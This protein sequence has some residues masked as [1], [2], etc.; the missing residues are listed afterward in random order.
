MQTQRPGIVTGSGGRPRLNAI[1][2]QQVPVSTD[3]QAMQFALQASEYKRLLVFLAILLAGLALTLLRYV[4]GRER[5]MAA[6]T[7]AGVCTYAVAVAYAVSLLLALRAAIRSGR[8]LPSWVW[9]LSTCIEAMVPVPMMVAVQADAPTTSTSDLPS[10]SLMLYGVIIALSVLRLRP[11]LCLVNGAIG[12]AMW[13]VLVAWGIVSG[14]S[15][16]NQVV[17]LRIGYGVMLLLTGVAAAVVAGEVR[18]HVVAALRE[19]ETRRRLDRVRGDLEIARSIQQGLLP[20][21]PPQVNGYQVAGWNLPADQTGGDYYDWQQMPDGRWAMAIADV[22]GH[23]IGP[24]LIMAACRAYARA[25]LPACCDLPSALC[26]INDLLSPDITGG[27]FI[28]FAI[29]M[30]DARSNTV[31]LLS[32]GHGPILHY[33]ASQGRVRALDSHGVPLGLMPTKYGPGDM[34]SLET[35]D[36]LILLTDGFMEWQRESDHEM[37][38]LERLRRFV[39]AGGSRDASDLIQRLYEDVRAFAAG[40][41]QQDDM[42]AVVIRRCC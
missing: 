12:A 8:I 2:H 11:W 19:A 25:T 31:Q 3:L 35:G 1:G 16:A 6:V 22:T 20:S 15:V 4:A 13:G 39:A 7:V 40:S 41:A 37:Y 34:L 32:A 21:S 9:G 36:Q 38:G 17:A 18:R 5:W 26:Q 23:G 33:S 30:L 29:A 28:T 24:A 10:P 42:T 14:A 27:R